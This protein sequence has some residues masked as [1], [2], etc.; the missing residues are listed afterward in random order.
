MP[1]SRI[2]KHCPSFLL[3][4][5]LAAVCALATPIAKAQVTLT[6]VSST[7]WDASNGILSFKY[8]PTTGNV[9]SLSVTING[10][11][12]PWLDT[13]NESPFGHSVG[14]YPLYSY[15]NGSSY[16]A[17]TSSYHLNGY[18]DIWNTK[19]DIPGTDPLEIE[20]HYV[21]RAND[22]GIHYYQ[23]LR[24][25]SG[26]GAASPTPFPPTHTSTTW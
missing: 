19:A 5:F 14:F 6:E 13:T 15:N 12:T 1:Q 8:D 4:L 3:P 20:N 10:T 9:T 22:A 21:I 11:T 2:R 16:G 23:V 7:E 18:L 17:F 26:D 25:F 24:H